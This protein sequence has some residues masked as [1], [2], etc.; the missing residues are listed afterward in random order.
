M[1]I[2]LHLGVIDLPYVEEKSPKKPMGKAKRGKKLRPKG[3]AKGS[4]A[5]STGDVASILEAKYHVMEIFAEENG[6][7]IA[8]SICQSLADAF[9]NASISGKAPIKIFPTEGQPEIQK[10]F[11]DF[12][13]MRK[14]DGIQPGV[15]TK[16]SLM[17]VNSR[18]KSRKG[19]VRPS[20]KDTGAYEGTFRA[21]V[22]E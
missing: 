2:R 12:I 20:F 8:D 5:V 13:D 11:N 14:M 15:P 16:A 6:Q 21:W 10:A 22:E 17:G 4:S 3:K 19:P 9:E 7:V 18:L 1:S